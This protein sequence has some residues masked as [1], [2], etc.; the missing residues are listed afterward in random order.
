MDD[1][2]LKK[3]KQELHE[4]SGSS[5]YD[6]DQI[7]EEAGSSESGSSSSMEELMQS[8]GVQTSEEPE[9]QP[10]SASKPEEQEREALASLQQA[11]EQTQA[12]IEEQ[13]DMQ[14]WLKPESDEKTESTAQPEEDDVFPPILLFAPNAFPY[15]SA[16]SF[17]A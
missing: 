12:M 6:V 16:K 8:L 1:L 15:F 14:T 11:S 9:T 10:L 2:D 17:S 5:L 7:M 3:L 13:E 4:V